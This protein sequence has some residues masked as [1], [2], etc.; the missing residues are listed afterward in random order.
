MM[1]S[2][3]VSTRSMLLYEEHGFVIAYTSMYGNTKAAVQEFISQLQ[4]TGVTEYR[5]HDLRATDPSY[6]LADFFRYSHFLLAAP[7]YNLHL[8]PRMTEL[9]DLPGEPCVPN[10]DGY[11]CRLAECSLARSGAESSIRS[12]RC[13]SDRIARSGAAGSRRFDGNELT[14]HSGFGTIVEY[15]A[16][17]GVRVVEG[18]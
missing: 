3:P 10:D 9:P 4:T 6:A 7:T 18:A 2:L 12:E 14:N 8:Y 15:S 13:R 1:S 16:R 5:V 11:T 17:R